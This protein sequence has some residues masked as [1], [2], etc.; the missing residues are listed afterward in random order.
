MRLSTAIR[1]YVQWK[2]Y[3]GRTFYSGEKALIDFLKHV[4]NVSLARLTKQHVA[5]HLLDPKT[6]VTIW[7]ARRGTLERF[8]NY[9]KARGQIKNMPL[10]LP[11]SWRRPPWIPHIYSRT[12]IRNL[13]EHAESNQRFVH[14]IIEGATLRTMLLFLYGTGANVGEALRLKMTDIDL[15][16]GTIRLCRIA[17]AR[18]RT[19]PVTGRLKAILRSYCDRPKE[20]YKETEFFFVDRLGRALNSTTLE[21]TFERLRDRAGVFRADGVKIRPF[22][23]DF[24]HTF[25][26]HTLTGWLDQKRDLRRM[27]PALSAYLGITNLSSAE[28]YLRMLPGRFRPQLRALFGQHW[29]GRAKSLPHSA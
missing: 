17:D 23:E 2:R 20:F 26:V 7:R 24:R 27:L 11:H 19:I 22:L 13:I 4:G 8:L 16:L 1:K 15:K 18:E 10:S 29:S 5:S 3:S 9:W 6:R 25:A 21:K 12:Q 28:R 14:C